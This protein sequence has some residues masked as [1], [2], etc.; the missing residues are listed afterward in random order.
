LL[1]LHHTTAS[2]RLCQNQSASSND[3]IIFILLQKGTKW[4]KGVDGLGGGDFALAPSLGLLLG[5]PKITVGLFFSFLIGSIV[6][7]ILLAVGKR[8][9]GQT[10]PFGPFL[11]VGTIIGLIWGGE[12]WSWYMGV[13]Q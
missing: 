10:V 11:V 5:W 3:T 2:R 12:I 1:Q 9:F 13:L 8:R 7:I 4:I 6:G